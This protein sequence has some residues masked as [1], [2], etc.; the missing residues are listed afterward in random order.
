MTILEQRLMEIV[1]KA[2]HELAEQ[3]KRI[4]DALEKQNMLLAQEKI[5]VAQTPPDLSALADHLKPME[6]V[7]VQ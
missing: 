3:S 1:P 7:H 2:L 6:T 5:T 4:A